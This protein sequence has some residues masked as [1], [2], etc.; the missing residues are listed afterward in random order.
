[1]SKVN[2]SASDDSASPGSLGKSSEPKGFA[3]NLIG[4][5]PLVLS[6]MQIYQTIVDKRRKSRKKT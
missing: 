5:I 1:M 6:L 3:G 2:R 4:M